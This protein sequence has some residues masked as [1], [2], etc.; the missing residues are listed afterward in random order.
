[1]RKLINKILLI[2]LV[3]SFGLLSFE[4]A[5][6]VKAED[7]PDY[8]DMHDDSYDYSRCMDYIRG[9][10]S[11]IKDIEAEI[12]NAEGSL[13]A[14]QELATSY[15]LQAESLDSEIYTLNTQIADLE[16][17]IE[18]LEIEI[19]ENQVK[20]DELNSRVKARMAESQK[21][22]HFN[23]FVDFILRSKGFDDMLR[24][25]YGIEAITS[26]DKA[27]REELK[28][29]IAKLEADKAELDA[30]KQELDYSRSV[31][32]EK[33][34]QLIVM[35]NYWMEI[36]RQTEEQISNLQN[37]LEDYKQS[38]A[39]LLDSIEDI[40]VL[41]SSAGFTRPVPG[42]VISAGAWYYPASFGGGVHLGVDYAVG[43]GTT[44]TAPINGI[45][46]VSSDSCPS[47]GY[48]GNGCPWDGTGV[49]AGGNQVIMIGSATDSNGVSHVYG[50]SFFHMQSGSPRGTGV[51]MQGE[52][53][54][55]VGSSG[56]STG[57]HCHIELYYLGEGDMADIQSDY[58]YRNYSFSFNCGWMYYGLNRLCENGVGAPC[59]LN[60]QH[61]FGG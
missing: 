45:V 3:L 22:M 12:E 30:S 15:A 16:A 33:Q 13:Q 60:P 2:L 21:T 52:Y 24:R 40:S 19:E 27:D 37:A 17:K 54:G 25:V 28:E 32:L 10:S 35:R 53:I 23:P 1:M 57:P 8:C 5:S 42:A 11:T 56:N 48:L 7:Y 4:K 31:L 44:I 51:V 9:M 26:K 18:A 47:T 41:P 39:Y 20:V 43:R 14:A 59:R 34:A 55:Q 58:L 50:V 6:F 49:A 36:Q 29:L 61:Y 38:Y 46:I